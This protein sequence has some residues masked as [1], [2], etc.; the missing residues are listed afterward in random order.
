MRMESFE[1]EELLGAYAL[2]A[3]SSNERVIVERY[4]ETNPRARAEVH[5]HREVATMLAY[6]GASAPDGLW[7]KIVGS[8]EEQAPAPGP[9]LAKVMPIT[10]ARRT[11]QPG[12]AMMLA[13]GGLAAAAA[14]GFAVIR[15]TSSNTD[16]GA[17]E[18]AAIEARS[19]RDSRLASLASETTAVK[20]EAVVDQDG[21]GYLLAS[22]L[23]A[24]GSDETYQLWGVLD[25][26]VISLGVLG[27]RPEV[28]SFSA[29]AELTTLVLTIEESGGVVS[30]EQPA[31]FA[32]E[33][34]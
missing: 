34:A 8:L 17:L 15:S 29:T 11:R 23:P 18:S 33:L 6:T 26:E 14:L 1:I 5:E 24:L 12:R 7:D 9:E 13:V 27:N 10:S 25:G 32:G 22:A 2:D 3:V 30:S 28:E 31:A 19:D 4:L 20:V 16:R 21:H